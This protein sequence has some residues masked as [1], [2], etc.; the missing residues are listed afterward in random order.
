VQRDPKSLGFTEGSKAETFEHL[1]YS[2]FGKKEKVQE[3][4]HNY[5][6]IE[7]GGNMDH[8]NPHPDNE[9]PAQKE[10]RSRP[11]D[12]CAWINNCLSRGK[13]HTP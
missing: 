12:L 6:W 3:E 7:Q 11:W 9:E 4:E 10:I 13:E 1:K 8:W 2:K 5:R